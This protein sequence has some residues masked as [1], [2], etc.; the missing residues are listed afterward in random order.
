MITIT[1][2]GETREISAPT[3]VAELLTQLAY[4][5]KRVAVEL[6]GEIAPRSQHATLQLQPGDTVE[7]VQAIGGG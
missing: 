7:I 1:L 2:N 4:T 3:T 5:G 6:N